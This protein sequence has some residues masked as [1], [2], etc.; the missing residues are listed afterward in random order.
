VKLVVLVVGGWVSVK[1]EEAE[2]G[3]RERVERDVKELLAG[4]CGSVN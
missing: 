3:G 4:L 2:R 1:W